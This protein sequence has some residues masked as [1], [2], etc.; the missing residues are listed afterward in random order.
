MTARSHSVPLVL[1]EEVQEALAAGQAVVALESSIIAQGMPHPTNIETALKVEETIRQR[2]A[3]PAT[4]ALLDGKIRVGLSAGEIERL[5]TAK[6][7]VKV[8][9][10]D[11]AR[12]LVTK[13]AGG[14]TVSAT[15]T[16]AA[17]AGIR[18]FA[19]GGIGGVHRGWTGHLDVSADLRAIAMARVTV[20]CSG[21]KAFL[22]LPATL[23]VLESLAV[24]VVGFRT[25][26]F[27]SF[28]SRETDLALEHRAD[29][30]EEIAR[31][32][33]CQD[34]L[35]LPEGMVVVN[36]IPADAEIPRAEI[37]GLIERALREAEEQGIAGKAVTPFVLERVKQ[38]SGG[39]SLAANV[40]LV[41]NNAQVAA[42][43]AVAYS[44]LAA[45]GA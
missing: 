7:A 14:T 22:D 17:L 26:V 32:M 2:G 39:R 34:Q 19:T 44:K 33:A 35:G 13:A 43:I 1:T 15:S 40:A 24:A 21:A 37:E 12:A 41:V 8:G 11:L 3:V 25:D 18:T 9:R 27:P 20:V 4:T 38:L 42:D 16:I 28:Y 10:R 5:G 6:D 29:S 30:A 23:E 31:Q 36:P 45:G